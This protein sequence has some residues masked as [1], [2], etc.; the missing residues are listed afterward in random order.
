ML[1]DPNSAMAASSFAGQFTLVVLMLAATIKCWTISRRPTTNTKCALSLMLLCVAFLI[2]GTHAIL[3]RFIP[4]IPANRV[5]AGILGLVI[6]GLIVTAIILAIIGLVEYSRHHESYNQGRSQAI[7]ALG[8]TVFMLIFGIQG[9]VTGYKRAHGF[10]NEK[11]NELVKF[12]DLNFQFRTP[13]YPWKQYD[14]SKINKAS[15]L[16]LVRQ[17]PEGYFTITAEKIGN[18]NFTSEQLAEAGKANMEVAST[19]HRVVNQT[20][21]R[22]GSLDGVMVET[23]AQVGANSLHYRNWYVVTNGYAYQLIGFSRSE[24]QNVVKKQ[25]DDLFTRFE[26][27]DPGRMASTSGGFTTNF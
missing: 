23:E 10:S 19:S 11:A 25:L 4:Y 1:N 2:T 14:A 16:S 5:V 20:P 9:A 24:D 12:E 27:I 26:V 13:G 15:K 6:F 21:Y 8:L 3:S 17:F 22:V 7:S 18:L